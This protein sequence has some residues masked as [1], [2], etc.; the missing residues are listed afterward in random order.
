MNKS[1][2]LHEDILNRYINPEKI[3]KAP[4]GF[5][6]KIMTRIQMERVPFAK[7]HIFLEN[8]R[9]PL[10]SGI[11]TVALI[12]SAI[13]VPGTDKY[14]T[15]LS[16]LK[17]I[18]NIHLAFPIIN[19]DKLTGFTLPTWMIYIVPAVFMLTLFDIAFKIFFHREGK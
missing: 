19:L 17:P 9:I 15:V 14:S 7:K 11:I 3:E 18:N 5:T 6:E 10:I 13:L 4:D 1:E 16:V 2:K 8:Y 12:I